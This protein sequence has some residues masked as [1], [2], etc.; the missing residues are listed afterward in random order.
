MYQNFIGKGVV[1][2]FLSIKYRG[3]FILLLIYYEKNL[4]FFN[5]KNN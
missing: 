2:I 3:F 5:I 1:K 4:Q